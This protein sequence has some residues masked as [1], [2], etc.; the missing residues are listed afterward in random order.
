MGVAMR[1]NAVM[2][3]VPR[4][5][6][7]LFRGSESQHPLHITAQTMYDVEVS[8]RTLCSPSSRSDVRSGIN[9][10]DNPTIALSIR[11]TRVIRDT[12]LGGKREILLLEKFSELM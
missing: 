6:K 8:G 10:T 7:K 11:C 3:M 1:I 5:P 2:K 12:E 9:N 4:R